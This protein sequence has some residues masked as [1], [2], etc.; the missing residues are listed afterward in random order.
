MLFQAPSFKLLTRL[1]QM[2]SFRPSNHSIM[3]KDVLWNT[4][5]TGQYEYYISNVLE[6]VVD[7]CYI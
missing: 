6:D 7:N 5:T 2:K 1:P 3:S 4:A